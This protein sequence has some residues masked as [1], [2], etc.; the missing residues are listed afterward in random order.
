[1]STNK[2]K[3]YRKPKRGYSKLTI[4]L[5]NRV[6]MII[7]FFLILLAIFLWDRVRLTAV[8]NN[9]WK[10]IDNANKVL[11]GS[12]FQKM[13]HELDSLNILLFIYNKRHQEDQAS[14]FYEEMCGDK[15]IKKVID[16]E[17]D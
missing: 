17:A 7:S 11:D 9:Q 10:V 13:E 4:Y 15:S 5:R 2:K 1:M 3:R 8:I 14:M 6:Y 12:Y 16:P